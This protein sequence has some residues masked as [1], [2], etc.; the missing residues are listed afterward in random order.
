[1]P[2]KKRVSKKNT[3][4]KKICKDDDRASLSDVEGEGFRDFFQAAKRVVTKLWY[5]D[6]GSVGAQPL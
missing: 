6:K 4:P 3:K 1:M 5:G 2:S